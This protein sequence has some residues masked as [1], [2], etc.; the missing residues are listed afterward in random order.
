MN[1]PY[2]FGISHTTGRALNPITHSV[3]YDPNSYFF[4][5]AI[6]PSGS[7]HWH[8]ADHAK[9]ALSGS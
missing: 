9:K 6:H 5:D 7:I 2:Q 8:I 3:A 4:Y 1:Y